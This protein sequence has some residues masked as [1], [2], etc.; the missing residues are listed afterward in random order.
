MRP[1]LMA[2]LMMTASGV[3]AQKPAIDPAIH[4]CTLIAQ[5]YGDWALE[6]RR[7]LE[8]NSSDVG[9][10][11]DASLLKD[12]NFALVSAGEYV[13]MNIQYVQRAQTPTIQA[14]RN[15]TLS[16]RDQ[17]GIYA[18]HLLSDVQPTD[19]RGRESLLQEFRMGL[20]R[21]TS[22]FQGR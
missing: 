8:H 7:V 17:I 20:Y 14:C 6:F 19:Q 11:V 9:G 16:A 12:V 1:L 21:A 15:V 22:V 5:A 18:R 10:P 4:H 13:H 3:T 2:L